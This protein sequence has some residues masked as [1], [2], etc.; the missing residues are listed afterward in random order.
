M[1]DP[2]RVARSGSADCGNIPTMKRCMSEAPN[3]V[4]K[5]HH[6]VIVAALMSVLNVPGVAGVQN[7]PELIPRVDR[8]G[9]SLRFDFPGMRIGIAEYEE[10]PTGTTVFYFP[11]SVKAAVDVRG[12]APGTVNA[13]AL[14]NSYDFKMMDAVVFAGGSW[15][16]LSAATGV[17]NGIKEQMAAQG[18]VDFIAGVVAAI[19]YDVGGR[20][21]SR[22][23]PDDRLGKA[24]LSSAEPGWFPLGARGAGRFA[25]QGGYYLRGDGAD[26]YADWPHSGQGGAFREIG[27]TKIAVFTVVNALG[28]IVD[29]DG[30]IVRCRRSSSDVECPSI[31]DKLHA[32]PPIGGSV[33]T[34]NA[35]PTDNTTLTLVVTN[36]KLSY[37]A[38]KRV[39]IQVH[40]SMGRAIQPFATEDDGDVLYAVTTDEIEN[41]SLAAMDLGVLASELAWD[42]ILSSVPDL[43]VPPTP[44]NTPP[45]ADELR[46][47]SGV[48]EFPGGGELT[49]SVDTESL[50]A[51]FNGDGRIYFDEGRAYR[52]TGAGNGFFIFESPARDVVRFE[53]SGG[54]ITGLTINPGPWPVHAT[55]RR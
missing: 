9:P 14:M 24:A 3:H 32:F 13:T 31:T 34:T 4:L 43:P 28:T 25:M 47:Y 30:R 26:R 37:A 5:C 51:S 12:G 35:G 38:L 23:T 15:Y 29:R 17:A 52:M 6:A 18:D 2:V 49:V 41:P 53:E 19:I 16:G 39:A 44:L 27:P 1:V 48:Y 11:D 21:F 54:R 36:Q 42:A 55:R 8:D 40:G 20:R 7:A 46:I 45:G 33:Q 10:A 22:I 50:T